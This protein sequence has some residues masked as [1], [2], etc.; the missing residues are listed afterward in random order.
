MRETIPLMRLLNE[1]KGSVNISMNEKAEFKCT[2]FKD[3]NGCNEF[4]KCPKMRPRTKHIAIKYHHSRSKVEDGSIKI[5][6]VDTNDQQADILAKNLSRDQFQ[7]L[8]RL[9]CEW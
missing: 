9:V 3:N 5:E 7:K 8:R 6:R 1:V 2:V 4:A